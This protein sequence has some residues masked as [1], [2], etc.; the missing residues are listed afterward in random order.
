LAKGHREGVSN[1]DAVGAMIMQ[2][3]GMPRPR[4]GSRGPASTGENAGPC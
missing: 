2:V 3:T 1:T 4:G